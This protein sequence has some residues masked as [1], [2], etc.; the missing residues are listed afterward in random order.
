MSGTGQADRERSPRSVI[1][2][3]LVTVR[4]HQWVK[5][6]FVA[7]PLVFSKQLMDP[8][9]A[10]RAAA[11]VGLFCAAS[12]AIYALNDLRDAESDRNHPIKKRRPIAAGELPEGGALALT[13]ALAAVAVL[14][15]LLLSPMLALVIAAYLA[16]DLAY[17]FG[18]KNVPILD[19]LMI[20]AG[21]LLR[22]YGGAVAI[23]VPASPWLL[24]CTGLLAALLGF[25][26]RAHE[27][28]LME[29]GGLDD[30]RPSL[31]G[32]RRRT[33]TMILFVLAMATSAAY[34]LYTQ[35]PHTVALFDTRA[36]IWTLPFCI[37][38][39]GRFLQLALS[40]RQLHSP[41]EAMLRDPLFLANIALWGAAVIV[42]V[43]KL[44]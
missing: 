39:I 2:A 23:E 9:L 17:S 20:A 18:L 32:Y 25:G 38:G 41:T 33:L 31:H 35:D 37:L 16:K 28:G 19:V 14:G 5:N 7:A 26:K 29:R 24:A 3:A 4:P 12:G 34:A 15:S 10:L 13:G 43:Y 6:L 42:I 36:L 40:E 44:G 1:L 27:L 22:V 21:V 11:A 8:D 30:T